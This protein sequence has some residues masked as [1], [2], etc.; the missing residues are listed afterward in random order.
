MENEGEEVRIEL[1]YHSMQLITVCL[2][3][4]QDPDIDRTSDHL[5][6]IHSAKS[7]KKRRFTWLKAFLLRNQTRV[8]FAKEASP[9]LLRI[10]VFEKNTSTLLEVFLGDLLD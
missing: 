10:C 4:P 3:S 1:L 9:W 2:L 8:S 6:D 5:R 7:F